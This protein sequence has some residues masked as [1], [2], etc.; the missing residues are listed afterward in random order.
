MRDDENAL[1]S[2]KQ[3]YQNLQS[4]LAQAQELGR[5]YDLTKLLEHHKI[6]TTSATEYMASVERSERILQRK[7]VAD[8][9]L[10]VNAPI[11]MENISTYVQSVRQNQ[12]DEVNGKLYPE[13]IMERIDKII[14][15]NEMAMLANNS[16]VLG[17]RALAIND[18]TLIT[19]AVENFT[20]AANINQN[21]ISNTRNPQTIVLLENILASSKIYEGSLREMLAVMEETAKE[22]ALRIQLAAEVIKAAEATLH[23]GLDNVDTL[24]QEST[25][26][27]QTSSL[28]MIGGVVIALVLSILIAFFIARGII[29]AI[30]TAVRSILEAND[31]VLSASNEIA[32]S[33]TSLAEGASRQAS[34]VE[35]VSATIEESTSINTQ[36]AENTREADILAKETKAAAQKGFNKGD[37]LMK[38]MQSINHSSERISKIIKTI[39]EI[40]SQ[41]KLLALNAA[42]EAARAGEHGLGFAVVADEVKSLAQRS[43]DAATE[44]ATIIEEAI[45]QA[46]NGSSI[47]KETSEAFEDILQKIEKTSNL[48]SEVSISAKEQS[49]GMNQIATAMGEIDQITQQNAATSEEAAA[50]SEE[51]NAQAHSMKETVGVIAKMVGFVQEHIHNNVPKKQKKA[52]A[53]PSAKLPNKKASS[54]RNTARNDNDVFPLDEDDLKEF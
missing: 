49:E 36:N 32:D 47:S 10:V 34:S 37:E 19:L 33:S 51:L 27:L 11:I 42:V 48:I 20:K 43:A 30:T 39:D 53:K 38:A 54:Q 8:R 17:Q 12:L 2:A 35:E 6:A 1:A 4:Y 18:S 44:T 21:L 28:V 14:L 45:V 29:K 15:A 3:A 25:A 22:N 24:S 31:Q 41:T 9:A 52:L 7:K 16:R 46:K 50:A 40:A 23:L 13:R 26:S 5:T